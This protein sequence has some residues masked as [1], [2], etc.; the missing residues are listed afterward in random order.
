MT[1]ALEALSPEAARERAT[2]QTL[3][4]GWVLYSGR[5]EEALAIGEA[6]RAAAERLGDPI[7]LGHVHAMQSMN[8]RNL[9]RI[10]EAI[11]SAERACAALAG[12]GSWVEADASWA[13][14]TGLYYAGRMADLDAL[15]ATTARV[16][17]RVGHT[18][19]LWV[20]RRVT[21]AR[22]LIR[23]GDLE[24]Y[25]QDVAAELTRPGNEQFRFLVHLQL[26]GALFCQGDVADAE[27]HLDA[28]R[29]GAGP[30][31]YAGLPEADLCA[32]AAWAGDA[33]RARTLLPGAERHLARPGRHNGL[34]SWLS[35]GI[36]ALAYALLGDRLACGALYPALDESTRLGLEL[37]YLSLGLNSAHLAAGVAAGAAGLE[38]RA[39]A[40]FA[41]ARALADRLES[42][43]LGPL[44]D[45][46]QGHH[47]AAEGPAASRADGERLLRDAAGRFETLKMPL[48]EGLARQW[49]A[50]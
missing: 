22:E 23:T 40:H 3:Y 39:A 17:D 26:A 28:A 41:R 36:M 35:T 16:A 32:L 18:F 49:L 5:F 12:T 34:G 31:I 2:L 50:R 21:A 15:L 38:A 46:W 13:R 44:V 24:A 37:D 42:P 4:A 48:H 10:D 45:L 14:V 43:L 29:A 1:R 33:D 6:A 47:L 9:G 11:A 27:R 20:V 25:R 8:E 19:A 7:L 30:T